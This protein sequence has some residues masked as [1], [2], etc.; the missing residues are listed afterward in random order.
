[1]A[2]SA[3]LGLGQA[4][5]HLMQLGVFNAI[6]RYPF[7]RK[8]IQ[9]TVAGCILI[10]QLF[11]QLIMHAGQLSIDIQL[12]I[13]FE[14]ILALFMTFF[15]F[16]AFPSEDRTFVDQWTPERL[17]AACIIGAMAITGMNG[18]VF[19][20]VAIAGVLIHLTILLAAAAGGLPFSTTVAM[21]IAAIIGMAELSFAG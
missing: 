2:G 9:F 15:L 1:M 13:G 4:V 5:I 8:S 18:I 20:H 3:F 17:G 10:V 11:W 16:V 7:A 14:V 19:G 21:I 12:F 6:I